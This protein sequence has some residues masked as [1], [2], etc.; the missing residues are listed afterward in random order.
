MLDT[1]T[2]EE[3]QIDCRSNLTHQ[4]FVHEYRNLNKPVILTDASKA[5][6]ASKIF[7]FE[8]FENQFGDKQIEINGKVYTLREAIDL[9]KHSTKENPAPYPIKL[10]L[11][12][13]FAELKSCVQ[14]R[15]SVMQPDR[16]HS[17]L[18]SR[19]LLS[20]LY[21]LEVFL[22]GPGGEF[23]YLHYDYLGLYAFINQLYGEKEFTLFSPEQ[24]QYLY[25][26]PNAP[27][28]SQIED[29]RNP[30]LNQYPLFAQAT[31][32]TIVV[33]AGETLFIPNGWYHTARSLTL[34]IS[35]ACDQL[36]QSNWKFFT[37]E[38]L[39]L[40]QYSP[41]KSQLL[42][43]YLAIVGALLTAHDRLTGTR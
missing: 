20:G 32:T 18:I 41:L 10:N 2:T 16:T 23:P 42:R 34:T 43:G 22:G 5:W 38:C 36:C 24:Q 11:Q 35:V 1:P 6:Q 40:K 4:E 27:W 19:K 33:S 14:P 3:I 37:N 30:D 29:H 7:S 21:D 13:D 28:L 15:L 17:P 39:M 26:Q 25:P 8:F 12:D 9:L 31:P